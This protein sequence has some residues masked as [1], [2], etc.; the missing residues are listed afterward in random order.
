[1]S[2]GC[3]GTKKII[4]RP[5]SLNTASGDVAQSLLVPEG[6]EATQMVVVE[7]MGPIQETFSIRSRVDRG[8]NYRFGNNPYHKDRTVFL[9][10]AN[11]LI[12]NLGGDGKPLYRIK[13]IT[14]AV[15]DRDPSVIAGKITA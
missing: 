6:A 8:I 2:C 1:M 15:E 12:G 11:Y 3:G 7:Y 4:N 9:A 5:A 14:G 10:D 13:G